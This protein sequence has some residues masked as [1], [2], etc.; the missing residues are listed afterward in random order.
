MTDAYLAG[1]PGCNSAV[2]GARRAVP[3][4]HYGDLD[5]AESTAWT[6]LEAAPASPGAA[7]RTPVL[8]T[9]GPGGAPQARTVVLRGADRDTRELRLFTDSRSPK[10]AAIRA[11]GRVE[12]AF[13]DPA[14]LIQLRAVGRA[15]VETDGPEA[16]AA[17]AGAGEGSRVCY[18]AEAAPGTPL[19][20]PGAGLPAHATGGARLS[21]RALEPGRAHFA[22]IRVAV[23][24]LDWLYL[25]PAGHRRAIFDYERESRGWVV[26]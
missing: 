2:P 21:A 4:A 18:L 19:A 23:A 26:P 13:F 9:L 7:F 24:R 10:A 1:R 17:W 8:A 15:Q 12:L 20:Q 11:D 6:M 14:G 25:D 16:D 22:L 3:P 5:A